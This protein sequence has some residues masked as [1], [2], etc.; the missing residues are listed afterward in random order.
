MK[1]IFYN[2]TFTTLDSTIPYAEAVYVEDGVLRAI[3]SNE[4]ILLQFGREGVER[5]DLLGGYAYP[6]LVDNHLH[7]AMQGMKLSML[8]FSAV[9]SK[10]EMLARLRE[11]VES[12]PKG[13]WVLGLNWNENQFADR[14][15]PTIEEL[16]RISIDHPILLTRTDYHTYLANTRAFQAAGI[17]EGAPNPE[18]GSFGRDAAGRFTGLIHENAYKPFQAA[19][20]KATYAELKEY[21]RLAM[22]DALRYG[23]TGVHTDDVRN[24]DTVG[25]T[26]KIYRELV[27]EGNALR[28]H[29]L[30][31]HHALDELQ[32]LGLTAGDGDAWMTIGAC[33][34]FADGSIG[35]RTAWLSQPYSDDPSNVG[36]AIHSQEQFQRIVQ[37]AR[38]LNM[39][40]AVHAIGDRAAELMIDTIERFPLSADVDG[41]L[42]DRLIHAQ[43]MRA[44]LIDRLTKL[45]V[46]I[47]IQPRF[48]VSDFPWVLERVGM[49][50]SAYV[51]AWRKLLAAGLHCGAGSDAP[52][53]P[54]DPRLG[55]HAA[56]TRRAPGAEEHAGYLPLEKLSPLEAVTL[57]TLGGAYAAGEEHVR[58]S[59]SVGKYADITVVDQSLITE[60][61]E[62]IIAAKTLFTIANGQIGYRQK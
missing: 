44:D 39:P 43:I 51:Y 33:K 23:I 58:G 24:L 32:S 20:P 41:R 17:H 15:I 13:K 1:R 3:G 9:H 62:Q 8:D 42:R 34:I 2:A 48:V 14:A 26:L 37:Q 7:L 52:I 59:I 35:G 11:K 57:F 28:T 56:V 5:I 38:Q 45:P 61:A 30:I 47:D 16:D 55:I 31:D 50:R 49:E 19:Q 46:T 54:I 22:Q 29:H 10:A 25:Q 12:T 53:E 4:E 6:G 27:E 60:D 21:V 18:G 40:I 36:M